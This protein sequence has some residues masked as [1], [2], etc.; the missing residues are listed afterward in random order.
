MS[1]SVP[2]AAIAWGVAVVAGGVVK[3]GR[4]SRAA[5]RSC[6]RAWAYRPMVSVGVRM[7]GQLLARLDRCPAGHDAGNER[8]PLGVEVRIPPV[9]VL[10]RQ[11]VGPFPFRCVPRPSW[12]PAA[13]AAGP[14]PGLSSASGPCSVAVGGIGVA[15][16]GVLPARAAT[17]PPSRAGWVARL[18]VAVSSRP[19]QRSPWAGPRPSRNDAGVRLRSSPARNPV[20]RASR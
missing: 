19:R 15:P 13:I 20:P 8:V 17:V 14:L 11:E 12:R 6:S 3:S 18:G 5:V 9:R 4:A 1:P 10:V 16:V 2:V 7:P